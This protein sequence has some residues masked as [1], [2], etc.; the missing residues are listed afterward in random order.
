M[1]GIIQLP[2]RSTKMVEEDEEEQ[3]IQFQKVGMEFSM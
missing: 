3:P 1:L 2:P